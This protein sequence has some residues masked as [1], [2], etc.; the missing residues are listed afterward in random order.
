M[1]LREFIYLFVR[2]KELCFS[3]LFGFVLISLAVYRLQTPSYHVS[4][5]LSVTRG[6]EEVT[7]DYRYDAF[8]RLQADERFS[9]TL[10]RY[11]ATP[12]A[13]HEIASRSAL[14]PLETVFFLNHG[15]KATR[16]S[17][18]LITVDTRV[19][20][21]HSGETIGTS[22]TDTVNHYTD[23]LNEKSQT[24]NWF[25]I[26]GSVPEISDARFS[27]RLALLVGFLSGVFVTFWTVLLRYFW[28]GKEESHEN[29]D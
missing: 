16:L 11:L 29:R 10:V 25:H 20:L 26:L 3:I 9:D 5:L 18:D 15:L 21:S 14:P 17:S 13:L 23:E 28:R 1:T 19:R 4:L 27:W 8:Y 6:R 24:P 7:T 2:K 12:Q 22:I